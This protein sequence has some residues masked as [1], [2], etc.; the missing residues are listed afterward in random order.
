MPQSS[1]SRAALRTCD[2]PFAA[3]LLDSLS[4]LLAEWLPR[5]RWFAGKG[6]PISGFSLVAVTELLPCTSGTGLLHL[7]VRVRQPGGVGRGI[8][9]AAADC[10]QLLLGVRD[11]LP[12]RLASSLIGRPADGP[13]RDSAVYEALDDPRPALVLLERLRSPGRVGALR[14]LCAPNCAVPSGLLPIPLAVEQ[15]N[16]SVVYGNRYILKVFRRVER[17]VN[18]D[19]ELPL[20][21]ARHGSARV[22]APTAWFET[23]TEA[24]TAGVG[25]PSKTVTLG[26]LQPFLP[27]CRDGWQLALNSLEERRHFT[28][29]AR[30]LGRATAEVHTGLAEV[31]P[32]AVVER[33]ALERTAAEMTERLARA[34]SAVPELRPYRRQLGR[35]FRALAE[36][37]RRGLICPAQR[38]H[39]DLHLG[40]VLEAPDGRWSLIDF[41]GEPARP[42]AERRGPQPVVRDIATMLRSFDYAACQQPS[43]AAASFAREWADANRAAFCAGYA[44]ASGSDPREEATLLRAY[45][46]DKTVYEVFYEARHRP[47]WLH[48]PISAV[49]RLAAAPVR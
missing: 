14:F 37:G 18:P 34:G 12:D 41:E 48:V 45:E 39:G 15:S 43:G 24:E 28:G 3:G 42:L 38:V 17:G 32:T 2:G 4:P 8:G 35:A 1:L 25:R 20:A 30:G 33:S 19:L 6:R 47:A 9:K 36:L 16:S 7:L 49:R 21:L 11:V 46:T 13:L 10:Y 22:P 27:G 40:Q 29:E 26:V 5:Q 23:G 44:E 31:L